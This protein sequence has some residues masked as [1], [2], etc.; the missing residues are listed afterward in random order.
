MYLIKPVIV[1]NGGSAIELADNLTTTTKGKALDARQ[2]NILY[3][4]IPN[5]SGYAKKTDI[6]D[7]S[8]FNN[9]ILINA[10]LKM[11]VLGVI[12]NLK[13]NQELGTID[14]VN[15][16]LHSRIDLTS[17]TTY[18]LSLTIT[19]QTS[20]GFIF[21]SPI[22]DDKIAKQ[23]AICDITKTMQLTLRCTTSFSGRDYNLGILYGF[24][25]EN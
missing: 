8:K 14:C 18:V 17:N 19:Q 20:Q 16:T 1:Q 4:R 3:N 9:Y 6:P 15:G 21:F 25:K 10:G 11:E 24:V 22:P 5:L 2:G 7:I 23:P 12:K 13:T